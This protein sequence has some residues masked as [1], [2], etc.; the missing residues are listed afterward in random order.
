[1]SK[2]LSIE[3]NGLARTLILSLGLCIVSAT[4]IYYSS[5][6]EALLSPVGKAILIISVFYG[7]AY[8]SRAHGSK[9]LVRGV[10][11]GIMFFLILLIA[12]LIFNHSLISLKTS[13]YTLLVC[14]GSGGLGGILGIG[15]SEK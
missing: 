3:I 14:A 8:V 7:G 2:R 11:M 15:L 1:M 9:G 12:T 13:L 6:S 4:V 5:L 10:Y